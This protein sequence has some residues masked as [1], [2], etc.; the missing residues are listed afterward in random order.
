MQNSGTL[1]S[2]SPARLPAAKPRLARN[3]AT[4]ADSSSSSP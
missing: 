4:R 3:E 2:I 1:G